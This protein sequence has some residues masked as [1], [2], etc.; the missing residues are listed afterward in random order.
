MSKYEYLNLN[1]KM[2]KIRRKIPALIRK[3][4]SEEVDYDFVK[5]DDIN[6]FL[7]PAL[8]RYGVDFDILGETPTQ[9]DASGRPVFLVHDG[10]LWRYEADM[11]I[12]WTNADRPQEQSKAVVHLIGM[13]EVADKAKG[14]AMTY[15]LKYYLLNKFNIPQN[16]AEDPDMRGAK[17]EN[18]GKERQEEPVQ[19]AET[20]KA[21]RKPKAEKGDSYMPSGKQEAGAAQG[22]TPIQRKETDKKPVR[23]GNAVSSK[24]EPR[25]EKVKETA[26]QQVEKTSAGTGQISFLDRAKDAVQ[27]KKEK[28]EP[29][30]AKAEEA[31]AVEKTAEKTEEQAEENEEAKA[32][33]ESGQ[34]AVTELGDGFHTVAETEEI[35]F[36]D[37]EDDGAF[38]ISDGAEP[39]FGAEATK[40]GEMGDAEAGNDLAE[41]KQTEV[42]NAKAVICNFGFFKGHT[43]GEL[44]ESL[45]G[46]ETIKWIAERYNGA[47]QEMKD[48][49]K[50]LAEAKAYMPKAA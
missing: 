40:D 33:K 13:H 48:A 37:A 27:E 21:G 47:N 36:D 29:E 41:E 49:A 45:K 30:S 19:K 32:S 24:T 1:Q 39:A 46:W 11:E 9:A 16:G 31:S 44:L 10:N 35:P 22:K 28:A 42:E 38:G 18:E 2:V 8:N 26:P 6:Q 17:T 3:R 14:T 12:C 43:L 23:D 34:N 5:L 50:V 4:Y 15:G 7:A 25:E 20:V